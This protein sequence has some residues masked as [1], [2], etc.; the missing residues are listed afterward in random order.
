MA[1]SEGFPGGSVVKNMPANA[2]DMGLIPGLGRSP[3]EGNDNQL[4]YSCLAQSIDRGAWWAAIHGI[5]K[6][7]RDLM[8]KQQQIIRVLSI[9]LCAYQPSVF[10]LWRYV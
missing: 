8:T 10:P 9:F 3:R 1:F 2:R 5:A 6:V 7:R 4:Q